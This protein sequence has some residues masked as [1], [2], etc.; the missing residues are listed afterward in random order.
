MRLLFILGWL[1]GWY[2]ACIL[3]PQPRHKKYKTDDGI[4]VPA[5][6]QEADIQNH[7]L[8]NDLLIFRS[9]YGLRSSISLIYATQTNSET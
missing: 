6:V 9:F 3:F 4:R 7:Q 5:S 2:T 8:E 1:V